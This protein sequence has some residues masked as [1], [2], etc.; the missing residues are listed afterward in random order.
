MMKE[1]MHGGGK[2]AYGISLLLPLNFAVDLK[3]L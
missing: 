2:E 3:S 1:A